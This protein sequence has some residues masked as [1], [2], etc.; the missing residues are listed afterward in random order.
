MSE[1]TSPSFVTTYQEQA[2]KAA[3]EAAAVQALAAC[4]PATSVAPVDAVHFGYCADMG[5]RFDVT[6]QP[7]ENRRAVV[8]ELFAAY[9]PMPLVDLPLERTQKPVEYLRDRE[10]TAFRREIFPAVVKFE[11][12]PER[13]PKSMQPVSYVRW[14]TRLAVGVVEVSIKG[15]QAQD[16]PVPW[17]AYETDSHTYSTGSQSMF[18]RRLKE[19]PLH[20]P[21]GLDD[22]FQPLQ[23][24]RDKLRSPGARLVFN[25]VV[26]R[27]LREIP[28]ETSLDMLLEQ[29]RVYYNPFARLNPARYLSEAEA[30]ELVELTREAKQRLNAMLTDQGPRMQELV[31]K[32]AAL[33]AGLLQDFDGITEEHSV[34]QVLNQ[35]LARELG[36]GVRLNLFRYDNNRHEFSFRVQLQ[37][38]QPLQTFFKDCTVQCTRGNPAVSMHL[39]HPEYVEI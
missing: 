32:G 24:F 9:T 31:S 20:F 33:V 13:A 30:T 34:T 19:Y 29:P 38:G 35:H 10:L 8:S 14:W 36:T 15:A 12:L 21:K 26:D 11:K 2:A 22:W 39:L 37:M 6:G 7:D 4:M 16:L 27:A 25:A 18:H 3:R 23:E 1:F 17:H 28:P 5:L